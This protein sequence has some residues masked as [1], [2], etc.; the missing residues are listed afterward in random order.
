MSSSVLPK[1][2][3]LFHFVKKL[4]S[5]SIFHKIEVV[6]HLPENEG[7]LPMWALYSNKVIWSP[8]AANSLFSWGWVVG[9]WLGWWVKMQIQLTQPS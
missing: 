5:S 1:I 3:V 8:I 6:F 4:R 9:G 2:E 7:C